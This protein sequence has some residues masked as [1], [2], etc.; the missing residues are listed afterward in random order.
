LDPNQLPPPILLNCI[1]HHLGYIKFRLDYR[2][3]KDQDSDDFS[4][5]L[6]LIGHSQ[7]DLYL[8]NLTPAEIGDLITRRLKAKNCFTL[9]RFKS[10]IAQNESGYQMLELPDASQW[11]FRLGKNERYIHLHPG[12]YSPQTL[13]VKAL[14]LKTALLVILES[15]LKNQDPFDLDLIN[16]VREDHLGASPIKRLRKVDGLGK[17]LTFLSDDLAGH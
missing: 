10:W 9:A 13:R 11:T 5:E 17:I 16:Q 14:S 2:S 1:K 4:K 15:K 7:L 12:R 8:G 6:L 3:Q